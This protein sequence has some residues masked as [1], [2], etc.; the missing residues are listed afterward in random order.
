MN[1][2]QLLVLFLC[3]FTISNIKAQTIINSLS[4]LKDRLD[5]DNGDFKMTPGTYYFNSTNCGPG[6]LFSDAR[7]LLFTGNN[8][9]FDFTDV[10][11]EIDTEIFTLYGNTDIIEFWPVGSNNVYKNLTLED[12]GMTVPSKGAGSVHLDGADNLIEGFKT[13]TRGSFPY[14]YGDIFGKGGGS[15]ISHN[16]HA[17]MLVRGDRNH[18]KN[19]TVIMRAYGHGI[20][21]QGS[22]NAVIEGCYIEGELRT[23]GEVLEEEGTGSPADNVD[24]ETVWGFNLKDLPSNHTFSL[25]EAGIRAY[26]T[27]VVFDENGNA[28][29]E[30][31]R[32]TLNTTVK[33]CTIVKMRVGVNTGAEGGDDKIIQN[34]T[35]LA[36]EVGFWLGNDGDVIDCRGD[37]SVGP[38]FSEDIGRSNAT[39]ELTL[40][41]NYIPRIGTNEPY[42]YFAGNNHNFTLHDG[43]TSFD[44]D[45]KI[46]VGGIRQDHRWLTGSDSPPM[47]RSGNNITLT[48]NTKYPVIVEN[49]VSNSNIISC[50]T[51][52]NHGSGNN[53]TISTNCDYDRDCNNTFDNLQAECYDD[54]SGV[55]IHQLPGSTTNDRS[56]HQ[57]STGDWIAFNN[58]EL[59]AV[60]SVNVIASSTTSDI[61]IEVR[62]GSTTGTLLA[63]VPITNTTSHSTFHQFSADLNQTVTGL[64]N[65]YF[66]AT[67][68]STEALLEI[69]QLSFTQ[70]LCNTSS[71]NPY[72]PISAESFCN[73]SGVSLEEVSTFNKVV[74][75]IENNDYIKFSN[76]DFGY[77]DVYNSIEVLASSATAGGTVEVRSGSVDGNLLASIDITNT[78]DWDTYQL[79]SSYTNTEI[80]GTHDIYLVFTGSSGSLFKLDNFYFNQ[81]TCYQ[82]TYNAY[83][84]IDALSYCEMFGVIPIN[85]EY[86]G[87]INDNEWIRYGEVDFSSVAPTQVTFNVAGYPTEA[88][89]ENGYINV[90]LDHPKEGTLI[91]TATVPKTGGWEVWEEVTVSLLKEVTG[92]HEV[93]LYFGNGAFNIDW[94]E[95]HQDLVILENLALATNGGIASQSSTAYEGDASRANDGNTNG[96]YGGGSVSHTAH[97]AD[98]VLK[99]WQVDLGDDKI[100]NEIVIHNR[101]GSSSNQDLN[102]FT[103]EVIN[104]SG[105]VKFS[106]LFTDYPNPSTSINTENVTGKI[107]K[108]SKT[109]NRGIQLAEVEVFGTETLSNDNILSETIK[110]HPN[111]ASNIFN[112]D[113]ANNATIRLYNANGQLVLTM[114]NKDNQNLNINHLKPGLYFVEISNQ[115]GKHVTKL[116]KN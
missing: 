84:E 56:I 66:V 67:S 104:A 69:D 27:G 113:G 38:L 63:T 8:S 112:I 23:V 52:T 85:N 16:K 1:K 70:D 109:S 29:D 44:S 114:Q 11:F 61:S 50:G 102:N 95:F 110:L 10:K 19:C 106:K 68:S 111:P 57:V 9:T 83:S 48:N 54:M 15:V 13:T 81:D 3:L 64:N 71:Y 36:C 94:F 75:Q 40:L 89:V 108:I 4:E 22:H 78:G 79:F 21:V 74:S 6:K 14:G 60:T 88:T 7:L 101:T 77:D 45:I 41:D 42:I 58:I 39:Y 98:G 26:S 115:N 35:A 20:F 28:T 65:I 97:A 12:I 107:V 53:I 73:A 34:C 87:G 96:N 59:S 32:Q 46:Q 100:I 5:D 62:Q 55:S 92:N 30:T 33:D 17:G 76:V 2:K 72:L 24:F 103:V 49:N 18:L 93:Y 47:E 99:W 105:E 90:M 25:Q 91:A 80:T 82:S 116:I 37:A 43:T 86:L 31:S 51:V